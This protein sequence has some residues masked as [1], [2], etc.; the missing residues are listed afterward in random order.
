MDDK[1]L[2][3]AG[4]GIYHANG[5]TSPQAV[6]PPQNAAFLMSPEGQSHY[7]TEEFKDKPA[8]HN[9]PVGL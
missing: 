4:A 3:P 5:V 8:P 1:R 9:D 6:V 2:F 7:T